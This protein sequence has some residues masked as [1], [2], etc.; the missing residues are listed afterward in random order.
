[1]TP[2]PDFTDEDVTAGAEAW[3]VLLN[4]YGPGDYP[5]E[6]ET[7]EAILA[8]VLPA[9]TARVRTEVLQEAADAVAGCLHANDRSPWWVDAIAR[10]ESVLRPRADA[11]EECC[12]G[13][14]ATACR[15]GLHK[16]EDTEEGK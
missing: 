13:W 16:P 8:A 11:E 6:A 10:A 15:G 9:Y 4:S 7:V 2:T 3:R 14:N 1:M 12:K 5:D